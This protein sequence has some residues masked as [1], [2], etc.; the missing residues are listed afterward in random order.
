[1]S[2]PLAESAGWHGFG[3]RSPI[4]RLLNIP[5]LAFRGDKGEPETNA[6]L[7]ASE[8]CKKHFFVVRA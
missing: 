2:H 6:S 3:V 4:P 7:G 5:Q 1:M 8:F